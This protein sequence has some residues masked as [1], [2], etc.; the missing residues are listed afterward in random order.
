MTFSLIP[1][2]FLVE[3]TAIIYITRHA[4]LKGM[5]G[6]GWIYGLL[7]I[8]LIWGAVSTWLALTGVYQSRAFLEAYPTFWLPFIPVILC[9]IPYLFFARAR[10]TVR[11]LIDLTPIKWIISIHALRILAIGTVIKAWR[12]AFSMSFATFVGIPDMLFG[13][14]ALWMIRLALKDRISNLGYMAWNM[15]GVF[16]ILPGAPIVG[17][18]GLPGALHCI[19]ETPSMITL[20]AFPMVLAPSLVVPI[21]VM[22]NLFVTIRLIERSIWGENTFIEGTDRH[23]FSRT[24]FGPPICFYPIFIKGYPPSRIR[25]Y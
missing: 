13:L 23:I 8:L 14:S 11:A 4:R 1:A 10:R 21:F 3:I 17:Q 6:A 22:M 15:L 25:R 9:V 7:F 20:Y 19:E 12:G 24:N 18:M 16:V 5:K 2:L